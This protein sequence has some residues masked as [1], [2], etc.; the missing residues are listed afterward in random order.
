ML[1]LHSDL[2]FIATFNITAYYKLEK[3]ISFYFITLNRIDP[4]RLAE[5]RDMA[6]IR[7]T[8]GNKLLCT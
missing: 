8:M 4:E 6:L 7:K 2:C 5:L 3:N 1:S